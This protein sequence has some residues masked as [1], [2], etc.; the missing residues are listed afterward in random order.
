M[1]RR[2]AAF[3]LI[4]LGIGLIFA[5]LTIIEFTLWL[6]HMFIIG[7]KW[8][9]ASAVLTLPFLLVAIGSILLY[10][11]KSERKSN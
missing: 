5:V 3:L 8:L 11:N 9:P 1:K 4:G 2:E 10:R 7:V 6:R